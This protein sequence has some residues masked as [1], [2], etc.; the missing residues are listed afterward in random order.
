M[1]EY[2]QIAALG[3]YSCLVGLV[4]LRHF[5]LKSYLENATSLAPDSPQVPVD[6]APRVSILVPAKDE[7]E[8]IAT[9]LETLGNLNYPNYEVLIVDDRSEDRTA[10][11]VREYAERDERIKLIQVEMLPEGWTGKTH[12]LQYAQQF[13]TGDWLWFV[14]ADTYHH[15]DT[16]SVSLKHAIDNQL[17]L[18]SALPRLECRSFWERVIQP[19]ASMCLVILYPLSRANDHTQLE[20]AW[21]NGQ[22]ILMNR[23]AYDG[24]GQHA[25]VRD[26][27]VE[28]IALA[29]CARRNGYRTKMVGASDLFSV[30]MYSDLGQI[31][32]GW[33]RIF[34]S[35]VDFKASR[36]VK[37]MVLMVVFGM[38]H[39]VAMFGSSLALAAGMSSLFMQILFAMAIVHSGLQ[40]SLYARIYSK[41]RSPKSYAAYQLLS[42]LAMGFIILKTIRMCYTHQVNW[43]G[44]QYNASLQN[45]DG[46]GSVYL[47]T[48][49]ETENRAA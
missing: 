41:T 36:L 43:R 15:P 29:K 48:P 45:S 21:A 25:S 22:F 39:Y 2:W 17:D 18:L 19:Y 44:T 11:I 1:I 3:L 49:A 10:E 28:D 37:L 4:A 6:A 9:C 16:L 40:L 33:S 32:R 35:A 7:E 13:A 38:S 20:S 31:V 14:D 26:K 5:K 30:R 47:E 27:F 24:M 42:S 46:L 8:T 12:A 23:A 34:Y